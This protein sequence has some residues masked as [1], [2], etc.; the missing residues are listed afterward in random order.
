MTD[1]EII[2]ALECCITN[3]CDE[4]AIYKE[5]HNENGKGRVQVVLDLI[6]R[7]QAESAELQRKNTELE[8]ELKAMRGAA[9]SYKAEA[10]RLQD[11]GLVVNK[12]FMDFVNKHKCEAIKEFAERF[13]TA[14][15]ERVSEKIKERNPHWYI[16]KR[17]V[18]ETAIEMTE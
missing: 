1:K 4:C 7:Q 3:K 11:E 18:R 6:K 5:C 9:N 15:D 2:K 17:I 14:L 12:T 16:V 10:E 8:I 13:E